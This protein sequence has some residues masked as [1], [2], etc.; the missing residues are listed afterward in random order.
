MGPV[1]IVMAWAQSLRW[2]RDLVIPNN[3]L[4]LRQHAIAPW[5]PTSSQYYPQL[6]EAV[7]NH[8]GIDMDMPV[9]D[10]PEEQYG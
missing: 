9:K 4:S 8:Y 5:E 2:I 7:A 1:R 10:L 3:E 6:L